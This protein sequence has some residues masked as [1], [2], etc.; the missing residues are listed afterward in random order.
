LD[1]FFSSWLSFWL[2]VFLVLRSGLLTL[3][4]LV[5]IGFRFGLRL[6]DWL[7]LSIFDFGSLDVFGLLLNEL[8]LLVNL[9]G[10]SEVGR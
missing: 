7:R 10:V 4:V 8:F 9:H 1:N 2:V 5:S 3:L 6:N